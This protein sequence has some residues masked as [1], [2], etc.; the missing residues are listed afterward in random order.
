MSE[1]L[2]VVALIAIM[3]YLWRKQWESVDKLNE[4]L[5]RTK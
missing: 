4:I 2:E 5:W 3:P 1:I